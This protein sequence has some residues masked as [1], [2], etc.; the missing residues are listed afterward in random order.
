MA[1]L[2]AG[3][4]LVGTPGGHVLVRVEGRGTH[5]NSQP[6]RDF[7]MEMVRRGYCDF[8]MDLTECLYVDSTFAG[9]LVALSLHVRENLGGH[10]FLFGA[11]SR[12]RE[13][14][15]TLGVE[16]LFEVAADGLKP[17]GAASNDN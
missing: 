5:M 10:V 13:Q 8:D 3:R 16:H 2:A 17:E 6:L 1:Q 9:V 14:F 7:V 15:H 12:C 4:V 11:N